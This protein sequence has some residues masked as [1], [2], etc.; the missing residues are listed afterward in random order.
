MKLYPLSYPV[1]VSVS[2]TGMETYPD[3]ARKDYLPFDESSFHADAHGVWFL[4][5]DIELVSVMKDGKLLVVPMRSLDKASAKA[6]GEA[7][8]EDTPVSDAPVNSVE[9][10]RLYGLE[11]F[12]AE[13]MMVANNFD[14]KVLSVRV[15]GDAIEAE[16]RFKWQLH[17][18]VKNVHL[19]HLF[20]FTEQGDSLIL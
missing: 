1:R 7:V 9:K 8:A 6:V 10:A 17:G 19:E 5:R 18:H 2:L 4:G 15:V 11:K 16:F 20:V 12:V 13:R 14:V 3:C